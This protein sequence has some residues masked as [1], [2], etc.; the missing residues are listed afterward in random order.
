LPGVAIPTLLVSI[1]FCRRSDSFQ[2]RGQRECDWL[3]AIALPLGCVLSFFRAGGRNKKMKFQESVPHGER[4]CSLRQFA[5]TTPGL[6]AQ[7]LVLLFLFSFVCPVQIFPN[8]KSYPPCEDN[9]RGVCL[10]I[11]RLSPIF[12]PHQ[13]NRK[14]RRSGNFREH[15]GAR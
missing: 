1:N 3:R 2:R 15:R 11:G 9:R 13:L 8:A 5:F 7:T 4:F 14:P 12:H 10:I 6:M